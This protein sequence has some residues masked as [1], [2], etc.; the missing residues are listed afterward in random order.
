MSRKR[1]SSQ[2]KP[3]RARSEDVDLV[4]QQFPELNRQFYSAVLP[5]H[6]YI[7]Q[8][9]RSLFLATRTP[10]ELPGSHGVT[11][12]IGKV[13]AAWSIT[14]S[15]VDEAQRRDYLSAETTVLLHH[16]A[17]AL[18]RLYLA[19]AKD[20]PCPWLEVARLRQ[21]GVFPGRVRALLKDLDKPET[22]AD[23][24][25]IFTSHEAPPEGQEDGWN[26][27]REG[28]AIFM[29]H[30]GRTI[31]D[32]GALYNAA[33]HG[34]AIR[35]GDTGVSLG[36]PEVEAIVKANGPSITYI[37]LVE[38][39]RRRR[40]ATSTNWIKADQNIALTHIAAAY[41][42]SLWHIASVRYTRAPFDGSQVANYSRATA[43]D[44][45]KA[46]QTDGDS[47]GFSIEVPSMTMDLAYYEPR[48]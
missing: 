27:A 3:P 47:R 36:S 44:V 11:M 16:A 26:D 45:F 15:L 34:L 14:D 5:P 25:R 1:R 29:A 7:K 10:E 4:P 40:W 17:E 18:L 12:E 39:D 22:Q 8:R 23:L 43:Q 32:D 2:Q 41:L 28:L 30:F 35:S 19:H 13:R 9:L 31:L 21:P 33:K 38:R 48:N 37:D 6:D 24:M 20:Q 42:Q 46:S